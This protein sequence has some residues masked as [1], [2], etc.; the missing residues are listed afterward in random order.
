ML[1]RR[2]LILAGL[3]GIAL[4]GTGAVLSADR[5]LAQ[6]SLIYT[7]IV[8]GVAVGGYDA[9]AYFTEGKPVQGKPEFA[10]DHGGAKWHFATAANRDAFKAEPA[11]YEPQYGGHCAFAVASGYTAKG[12]PLAW[13]V[14][15]G[16]LYL[17]YNQAVKKSWEA[18]IPGFVKKGDASWPALAKKKS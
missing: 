2:T 14:S 6:D 8:K 12:D 15:N 16:K 7:G 9:V 11:K 13:T 1:S 4:V 5:A 3:S 10:L 18:D 17:N